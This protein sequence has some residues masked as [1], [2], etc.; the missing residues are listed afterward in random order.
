MIRVPSPTLAADR[1]DGKNG[2]PAM[3][4]PE[5]G[6]GRPDGCTIPPCALPPSGA[7]DERLRAG[8]EWMSMDDAA[9][10]TSHP[11][12]PVERL[13]PA[14]RPPREA[15]RFYVSFLGDYGQLNACPASPD[16]PLF[17]A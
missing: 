14:R 6:N 13:K 12:S 8:T 10:A 15:R 5:G 9:G 3:P 2:M 16:S 11:I 1:R 4:G 7:G 17:P